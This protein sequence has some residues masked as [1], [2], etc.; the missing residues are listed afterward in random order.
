MTLLMTSTP[1][2]MQS[3]GHS[4]DDSAFVIQWHALAMF[5]PS[6][7]TGSL[8]ARFGVRRIILTGICL[9]LSCLI[10]G[11]I[12]TGVWYYWTALVCLGLGW[13]FMFVGSTTMLTYTYSSEERFGAQAV[14]DFFVFGTT[15]AG[16]LLAGTIMYAFGWF[17]TVITPI[18]LLIIVLTATFLV[19]QDPRLTRAQAG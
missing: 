8:I 19:R 7:F 12:G 17:T 11:L 1:L 10:F 15:A 13:N 2:A 3:D 14:N 9:N 5:G 4:F 6:F 18:P 16:S